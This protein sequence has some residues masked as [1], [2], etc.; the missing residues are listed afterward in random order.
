[1]DIL[2]KMLAFVFLIPGFSLV[3]LAKRLVK[4]YQLDE[5]IKCEIPEGLTEDEI[6]QYKYNKA[7]VT[8]KLIGMLIVIP[9]IILVFISF[10]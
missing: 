2:M 1:M 4:K 9:G 6:K 10:R 3:F 8:I 7:L 5:K